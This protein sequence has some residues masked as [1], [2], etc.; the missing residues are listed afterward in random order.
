MIPKKPWL[1][2]LSHGHNLNDLEATPT[3]QETS[4]SMWKINS[5][6]HPNRSSLAA[7]WLLKHF[8]IR[9]LNHGKKT[10]VAGLKTKIAYDQ[11]TNSRPS[12]CLSR[13]FFLSHPRFIFNIAMV[14]GLKTYCILLIPYIHH[15]FVWA[16]FCQTETAAWIT[17]Y[18]NMFLRDP[19]NMKFMDSHEHHDHCGLTR[20]SP[21]IGS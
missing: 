4:N 17:T 12:H 19:V 1:S 20:H 7:K 3:T 11:L 5:F 13:R 21:K 2:I 15:G 6:N 16:C 18:Y 14:N 9:H 10:N 8:T